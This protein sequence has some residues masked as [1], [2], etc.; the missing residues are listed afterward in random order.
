MNGIKP[1]K[2]LFYGAGVIGSL[3]AAR[4]HE[5]GHDITVLARGRRLKDLQ[6]QGI[7]LQKMNS[8]FQ[9]VSRVKAIEVLGPEDCYDLII[10]PVR[11]EQ[12]AA[13]IPILAAN[14]SPHILVMVNNP[15]G[16]KELKEAL[17]DRV[18]IGFPGAGGNW[19]VLQSVIHWRREYFSQ[20]RLEKLMV[21]L[22]RE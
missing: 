10:V 4:F 1:M 22:L 13:I 7:V 21:K 16:Y 12:L 19:M 17:E 18:C 6:E 15:L 5:H 9:S 3:Y 20:R 8:G 2:N 14:G 11:R